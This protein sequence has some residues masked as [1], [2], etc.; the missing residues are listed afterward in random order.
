M[1]DI[2]ERLEHYEARDRERQELEAEIK[3]HDLNLFRLAR[4]KNEPDEEF[5]AAYIQRGQ[6]LRQYREKYGREAEEQLRDQLYEARRAYAEQDDAEEQLE[7]QKGQINELRQQLSEIDAVSNAHAYEIM[8][9]KRRILDELYN[10]QAVD[11]LGVLLEL[12][13]REARKRGTR[14]P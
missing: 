1:T 5:R 9:I 6:L 4:D 10:F 3:D 13:Q 12:Q 2:E 11:L 8:D 14:E 7:S